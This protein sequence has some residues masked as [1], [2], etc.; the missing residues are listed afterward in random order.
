MTF[1]DELAAA[2][3]RGLARDL[4]ERPRTVG[5]FATGFAAAARAEGA[6]KKKGFLSALFGKGD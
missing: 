6:Q 5:E 3:M 1:P 4:S 2:V